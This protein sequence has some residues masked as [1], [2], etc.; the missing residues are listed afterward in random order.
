MFIFYVNFV[1]MSIKKHV[2]IDKLALGHTTDKFFS[3]TIHDSLIFPLFM[4]W[5]CGIPSP[6]YPNL[7]LNFKVMR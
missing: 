6:A 1:R 4:P 7:G 2:G 3:A 5:S